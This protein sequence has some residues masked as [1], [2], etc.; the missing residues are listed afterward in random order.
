MLCPNCNEKLEDFAMFCPRCGKMV[1]PPK[2]V[3]DST[4]S[5]DSVETSIPAPSEAS[6]TPPKKTPQKLYPPEEKAVPECT[7]APAPAKTHVRSSKRQ[8]TS[9]YN[10]GLVILSVILGIIAAISVAITV[11]ILTNTHGMRVELTK[12]QT[13]RASAQA[14]V[15]TLQEE[16]STLET[17]LADV[18]GQRDSLSDEVSQ[19]TSQ[20]NSMESSANQSAYDREAIERELAEAQEDV[21]ALSGQITEVQGQLTE[22]Q[23][24]LD[25]ALAEKDKLQEDYD[26]LLSTQKETEKELNFYDS[27]VVFVMLSNSSKYYHK[28]DCEDFTQKNFLAYSTKLAE[29]NGYT[30]CPKC[31]G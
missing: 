17:T 24:K 14:A 27:Y 12:A 7:V 28:Y 1:I 26:A 29:A 16:V 25:S 30:P 3:A 23:A 20:I 18:R 8:R 6:E 2:S 9:K 19:L 21:K 5:A 4:D 15:G 13:E 11:Y 22:T 31:C 10:R